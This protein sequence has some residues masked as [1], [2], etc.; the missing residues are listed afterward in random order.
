MKHKKCSSAVTKLV[1][2]GAVLVSVGGMPT[3]RAQPTEPAASEDGAGA[4]PTAAPAVT[5]RTASTVEPKAVGTIT[6]EGSSGNIAKFT[7]TNTIGSSVI[8][9]NSGKIGIG[10]AAPVAQLTVQTATIGQ[11]AIRGTSPGI[12][13]AGESSDSA[14]V[15]GTHTASSGTR[16][17][18]EGATSSTA[19]GAIAVLG[20]VLSS[21]PGASSAGV[22]GVNNGTG[23][24][25]IGVMGTHA[26]SG[27]GVMG[28]SVSGRG[29]YGYSADGS[30]LYGGSNSSGSYGMQGTSS[31]GTGVHGIHTGP[32]GTTPGVKG[33]TNSTSA[34]AIAVQGVV[35]PSSSAGGF[36]V[37]G[38]N[39]GTGSVGYGVHGAHSGSGNGVYGFCSA[40]TG[41]RGNTNSGYGVYGGSSTGYAGYF[42]GKVHV[43]GTLT[44]SSGSFKIDHPLDPA[45]KYLSHSFVESP[46]MMNIYNGNIT[47]NRAG[48]ATV[49][50]P[51]YFSALNTEFRY[52]LTAIGAPGPNLYVAQELKDNRFKIAGGRPGMRV[53]WQV[54]GVRCDAYARDHR[55]SVE[56]NKGK[57][58]GLYLYPAGF[59]QPPDKTIGYARQL[60]SPSAPA[61]RTPRTT[62]AQMPRDLPR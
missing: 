52:Q 49:R 53:S 58:A 9:E 16:A 57:D 31:S 36:G 51:D 33:E 21:S 27:W 13:V 18:V 55:I 59:H 3:L 37:Q 20:T 11:A 34:S 48:K 26:G 61:R 29:V 30:G 44:K 4:T 62:T 23:T 24:F 22:K 42:S 39:Y 60:D 35:T 1:L 43:N 28:T 47:L 46:D 38:L 25:G 8:I 50:M 6:G 2:T 41:V 40:G 10:T 14:G 7:G 12:G 15:Y 19:G 54:T 17:G 45:H 32:S 5:T 56:T